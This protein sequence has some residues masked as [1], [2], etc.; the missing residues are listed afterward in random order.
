MRLGLG[1]YLFGRDRLLFQLPPRP[2]PLPDL[3]LLLFDDQLSPFPELLLPWFALLL[4]D[5]SLRLLWLF[6]LPLLGWLSLLPQ[7]PPFQVLSY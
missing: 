1:D 3:R 4:L 6:R 2:P 5:G 7:S